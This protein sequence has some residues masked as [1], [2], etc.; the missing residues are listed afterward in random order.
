M[1]PRPIKPQ[2]EMFEQTETIHSFGNVQEIVTWARHFGVTRLQDIRFDCSWDGTVA[3][4]T[5]P[6]K[7]A[8]YRARVRAYQ[9]ELKAWAQWCTKHEKEIRAAAEH[10]KRRQQKRWVEGIKK[11]SEILH[12]TDPCLIE[13]GSW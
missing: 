1:K 4:V 6:E 2:R 7:M 13:E 8:D 9:R 10:E 5:I 11:A 3:C 12:K